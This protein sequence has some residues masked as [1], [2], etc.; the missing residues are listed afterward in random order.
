MEFFHLEINQGAPDTSN[1]ASLQRVA[2]IFIF[3]SGHGM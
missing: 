2:D 3:P 1:F